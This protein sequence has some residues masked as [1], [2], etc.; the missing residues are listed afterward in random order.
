MFDIFNYQTG[1]Y[2]VN[3]YLVH[4]S[5]K[6]AFIVDPGGFSSELIQKADELRLNVQYIIL[7]HGHADHIGGVPDFEAV[8]PGIK[9][10]SNEIEAKI[11]ANP[12]YNGTLRICGKE[13][14]VI[15]DILVKDEE[16]LKIGEMDLRFM[17]TPGHT[18]G[19]MSF[20]L[21]N[22]VFSGDTLF[23]GS[24]GRTDFVGGDYDAIINSIK[25]KLYTLPDY[26]IVLPGHMVPTSIKEEKENNPFVRG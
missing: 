16:H 6:N 24:I 21:G 11:L 9:I 20:T 26:M 13:V 18:P 19:S 22:V 7:T 17:M 1:P 4:D 15:C 8:Y 10:V 3:T 23:Q 14:S 2:G 5:Q 25:T 12:K